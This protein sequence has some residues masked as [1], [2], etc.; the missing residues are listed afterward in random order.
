MK[1]LIE[2]IAKSLVSHPEEVTVRQERHGNRVHI[3]LRVPHEEMGHLI[4]KE[5]RVANAM[6]NL[7][8]VVA[9][10]DGY[11]ATLDIVEQNE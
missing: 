2:F 8:R 3:E 6:R 10:R 7:L 1:E 5:G 9:A 4:G 11:Q